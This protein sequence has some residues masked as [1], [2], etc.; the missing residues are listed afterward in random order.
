MMMKSL[1]DAVDDLKEF[2]NEYIDNDKKLKGYT[3]V[4]LSGFID[5]AL[6]GCTAVGLA[7][8]GICIGAIINSKKNN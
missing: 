3:L 5:G 4:T 1:A 2:G 7:F 6:Y 8:T